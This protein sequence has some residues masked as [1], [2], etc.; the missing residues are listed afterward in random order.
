MTNT[1]SAGPRFQ[2]ISEARAHR[3]GHGYVRDHTR[4]EKRLFACNRAI[5]ELVDDNEH[6]GRPGRL[7]SWL[8]NAISNAALWNVAREKFGRRQDRDVH[9]APDAADC[10]VAAD[11]RLRL[12]RD[13]AFEEHVVVGIVLH[14]AQ[15]TR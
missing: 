10:L 2:D 8:R 7:S 11:D 1:G 5:D 9:V 15:R 12:K 14:N 4:I 6:A 13:G 3:A